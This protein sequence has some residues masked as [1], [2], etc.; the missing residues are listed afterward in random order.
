ML[1]EFEDRE[2]ICVCAHAFVD[3]LVNDKRMYWFLFED[4]FQQLTDDE[5]TAVDALVIRKSSR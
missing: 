4:I 3:W 1:T 2:N 5:R